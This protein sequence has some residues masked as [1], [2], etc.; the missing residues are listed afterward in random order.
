MNNVASEIA[1]W[2]MTEHQDKLQAW[3]DNTW[4]YPFPD[5]MYYTPKG[6]RVRL[7]SNAGLDAILAIA[8]RVGV[9][10]D[11]LAAAGFVTK[12][13]YIWCERPDNADFL[14]WDTPNE[15]QYVEVSYA[16]PVPF[17]SPAGPGSMWRRVVDHSTG[18]VEFSRFVE[19]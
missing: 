7:T 14:R 8:K 6:Q 13:V 10:E 5:G 19:A 12:D 4:Q 3:R 1:V 17:S 2:L 11:D 9:T 18:T 15:G 16:D